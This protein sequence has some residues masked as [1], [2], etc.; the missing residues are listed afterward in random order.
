MHTFVIA[1]AGSC[2]DG[3]LDQALRL[4]EVARDIGADACKFQW[5]SSAERLCER[6]HAPDYLDA[7][8]LIEFPREWLATLAA[9]CRTADLEFMC[10]VYLP[11][12][13]PV[14]S[15][16]VKR[17]KVASF[18]AEDERFLNQIPGPVIISLGMNAKA[19][20]WPG[21]TATYL[22][23]VSAYPTPVGEIG[24]AQ[25]RK[26]PFSG[27]SDHTR[28][29]WTG[30]LAVAAGASVI[31]FHMRLDDTSQKNAD[32]AVA[33]SHK[34]AWNYVANIRLAEIMLGDG[35]KQVMPSEQPMLRYR[36]TS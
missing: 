15:P 11:E 1:E 6:R 29:P 28:H 4:I 21:P 17:F 32:Y 18:E 24:L 7:Y 35:S 20:K 12:D 27:L 33:R 30:G 2:H 9:A 5:L 10:T 26:W 34:E 8:R 36:V 19:L 13:I 22:H 16:L 31:E 23:C 25:L 3:K 14:I